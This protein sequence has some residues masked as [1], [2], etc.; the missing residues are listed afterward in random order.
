[1]LEARAHQQ[2]KDLLRQEGSAPWP[3]HLSLSRLVARSLRRGDHTLVRLAPG[4]EPS[5]W[6]SLLVPLA[7]SECPL[8]I[9]VGEAQRQRLLQVE[10]PRLAKAEPSMALPCFEGDQAPE[11]ARVWLL[12][13][14]QLVAAW[15]KGGL[16]ERQLVIPEAEQLDALLRQALEVV[17]THQH[18]DQLRRAQ[19]AAESSLLSLHQRLNRRVLSAPRRPN[20]LVALAPDDEA[21]LRH[22]LQLLSPLPA[23][24]PDWLAAKGDG[25]TSW[26]QLNPQL[27]QWQLHR[28]PLEPLAVLRGL[29]EGRGAVLLGQL[30]PGSELGLQPDVELNLGDAPL[31]DPLPLFAPLRQPLPNSPNYG[32]HLLEQSRRLILG[33]AGLTVVLIDDEALRLGLTSG[34]AAEFGSRVGHESTAPESNGVICGRWCWW[35]E[36]QARLPLPSQIVIALLP[37]ASLEDPLTAARVMALR[38]EGRDWFREGLLPDALTRLQLGVA[39]LRREGAGRL[40]VLDGRLRGRSWG[41]QVLAALEPWI[42]L[43]RLLPH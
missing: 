21:P 9:V 37:I 23:P 41:R 3:H 18:W 28:H 8:A 11:A 34:L 35:L 24:W 36:Q 38:Q 27:L 17:V 15:Q 43:T 2:L 4:S 12:S 42:N 33:Q 7:L 22:L 29:L 10:L 20:Q 6:I 26:A 13:H 31:A 5:W 1:M 30:A 19:P 39:G 40:A 16:G 14:Q 32:Q 25:W